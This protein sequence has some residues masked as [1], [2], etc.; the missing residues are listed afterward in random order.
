MTPVTATHTGLV[1]TPGTAIAGVK[2][3]SPRITGQVKIAVLDDLIARAMPSIPKCRRAGHAETV[4]VQ[5]FV[6]DTGEISMV[7]P[8]VAEN[9][10]DEETA[11]C[12]S[13]RILAASQSGWNSK[14]G[15]GIVRYTVSLDAL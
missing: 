12:V 2:V 11:R 10:G 9:K 4:V 3:S 13:T 14:G 15:Q 8:Y 7:Q 6:Q 5:A 1:P